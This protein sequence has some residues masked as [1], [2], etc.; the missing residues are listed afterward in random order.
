MRILLLML[1]LAVVPARAAME[2]TRELIAPDQLVPGQPVRI[3]VT[4]WTDSWF[5][6]PPQWPEFKIENGALLTTPIPNQLLTRQ[7]NGVSWSGI[8]FE[9]QVM[10]WDQGLLRFP[11][12]D[13]TQE[14][15]AQAP[16]TV[17]LPALDKAVVW[18]EDVRQPDRFLPAS[19]LTLTQKI[20]PYYAGNDKTLHA[21]DA[22][23]RTVTAKA[24]DVLPGQI[25]ALLY[26]IPG[27]EAQRLTPVNSLLKTGRGEVEGAQRQETLRY[28]PSQA[29]TITLP[30]VRLRWWDTAHHQWQQAELPG[31]SFTVAA[32]R[33]AGREATLRGEASTDPWRTV[34]FTGIAVIL[35]LMIWLLRRL[36]LRTCKYLHRKWQRFWHPVPLP[37]LIPPKRSQQ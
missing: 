15:A 35:I 12:V 25:P 8:R 1:L 36:M 37:D 2:M 21:G 23:E 9:R 29:G 33:A 32:A 16:V 13:I 14:A 26:A 5:N 7:Q 18:P 4:F 17:S 31:T 24:T 10:A 30:P 20:T 34:I 28:L 11:A 6:P 3:A 27:T 19:S 22:I